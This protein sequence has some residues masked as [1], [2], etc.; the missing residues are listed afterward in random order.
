[1]IVL[2]TG[3]ETDPYMQ[4]DGES[5]V[6]VYTVADLVNTVGRISSGSS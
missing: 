2:G 6:V 4:H 1:M 5:A 3:V